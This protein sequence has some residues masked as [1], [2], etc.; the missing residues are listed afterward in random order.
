MIFVMRQTN[1]EGC[2]IASSRGSRD[3]ESWLRSRLRFTA[4]QDCQTL[5]FR[6]ARLVRWTSGTAK[7]RLVCVAF[8]PWRRIWRSAALSSIARCTA[9][10]ANCGISREKACSVGG[11]ATVAT[12]SPREIEEKGRIACGLFTLDAARRDDFEGVR[13]IAIRVLSAIGHPPRALIDFDPRHGTESCVALRFDLFGRLLCRNIRDHAGH[14]MRFG[15][16]RRSCSNSEAEHRKQ[17]YG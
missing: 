12:R 15:R 14:A 11:T 17:V 6:R 4:T 9:P 3:P 1:D 5:S 13:P 16:P 10:S 8:E 2:P 7:D